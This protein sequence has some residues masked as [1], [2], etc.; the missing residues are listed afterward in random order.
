[1]TLY[2]GAAYG[3]DAMRFSRQLGLEAWIRRL[4]LGYDTK[5]GDSL[6]LS[7]PDGIQ[8]RICLVRALVNCP[9]ILILDE[10]NTSLDK[11]G[12]QLLRQVLQNLRH[13]VTIIFVTHRPAIQELAD[14]SYELKDGMLTFKPLLFTPKNKKIELADE[15]VIQFK[16]ICLFD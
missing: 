11:E 16:A 6:F 2:R 3:E 9:K 7:L 8:Q 12:D 13:Q 1:M 5:I 15:L 14:A 10:A 4:P